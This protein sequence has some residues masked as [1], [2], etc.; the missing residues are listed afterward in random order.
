MIIV[1]YIIVAFLCVLSTICCKDNLDYYNY[2]GLIPP[3]QY[4]LGYLVG[5]VGF[6]ICVLMIIIKVIVSCS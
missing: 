4:Q 1:S 3:P 2:Y 5:V 6:W